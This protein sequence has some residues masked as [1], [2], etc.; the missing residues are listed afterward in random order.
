MF[1]FSIQVILNVLLSAI[2]QGNHNVLN[3]KMDSH[4]HK[5]E[6]VVLLIVQ[7]KIASIVSAVMLKIIQI[8]VKAVSMDMWSI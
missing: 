1:A 2:T 4:F 8:T 5:M 3:A 7:F 6:R